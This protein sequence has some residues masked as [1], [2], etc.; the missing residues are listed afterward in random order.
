MNEA[1]LKLENSVRSL[2]LL[3]TPLNGNV[4]YPKVTNAAIHLSKHVTRFGKVYKHAYNN[5]DMNDSSY[6]KK[7]LMPIISQLRFISKRDLHPKYFPRTGIIGVTLMR[8][9][10]DSHMDYSNSIIMHSK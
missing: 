9:V 1:L 3:F 4:N 8:D 5:M 7:K 2:S 6:F 10:I